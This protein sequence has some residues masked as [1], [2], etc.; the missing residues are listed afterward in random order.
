[1]GRRL[2]DIKVIRY[3]S[4]RREL[5]THLDLERD[6]DKMRQLLLDTLDQENAK[7]EKIGE[8]ELE[9]R[10]HGSYEVIMRYVTTAES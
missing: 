5:T 2:Y 4:K 7:V 8:Y 9:I 1:M 6:E 10:E 3:G